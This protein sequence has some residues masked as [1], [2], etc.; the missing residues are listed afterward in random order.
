MKS[1]PVKLYYTI[2]LALPLS[3]LPGRA[4]AQIIPDRTLPNNSIVVPNSNSLTINGGTSAGSNLFHS[5]SE[6][7]LPTG[8]EAIFNNASN[9]QNI[10]SR[11]TGGK[12]S[13]IDGLIRANGTANLFF[14]N[15]SGII[16][17]Q[18]ARLNIGG[19]FIGSTGNS[20]QFSD[21][22]SFSATNPQAPPLLTVNV[23]VG[24]QV[25]ANPGAIRVEGVGHRF[26]VQ[27]IRNSLIDRSQQTDRGLQVK[28]RNT[29]AL[30]GGDVNLSGG[31]L[32]VTE[33]QIA[34]GSISSGV[35]SLTPTDVGWKLG[36][37][38]VQSF[39][40]INLSGQ[41]A[42]DVSGL[43]RGSIQ[44][45]GREVRLRD[46]SIGLIQNQ[47]SEPP[48]DISINATELLQVTGTNSQAT[49]PSVLV[50]ETLKDGSG[51]KIAIATRT[52]L[53]SDG[54]GIASRTFGTAPSGDVSVNA[55]EVVNVSSFSNRNPN[56]F[57]F[58]AAIS[59][60]AGNAGN[61]AILAQQITLLDGGIIAATTFN[62]GKGG[63]ITINASESVTV[64]GI[65]PIF[66]QPTAV[67]SAAISEGNAG[68]VTI[69][70]SRLIVTNGGSISTSTLAKGSGETL[71]INA[72][73]SIQVSGK[74]E[75]G[76]LPSRI[77][78]SALI[79]PE[80]LRR[81]LGLPDRPSGNSG[82]VIINTPRLTIFDGATVSVANQGT[83]LAG[84]LNINARE[85]LLN[86][87]G[88][89]SASTASG[90]GGNIELQVSGDSILRNGSQIA[91]EAAG[92][93]NGGNLTANT[94]TLTI[95]EG[96]KVT[97][98]A[99]Q[100]NGGNIRIVTQ[101]LFT[102]PNSR[103]T[104]SSSFG[105]SGTISINN[106]NLDPSSGLVQ[107]PEN[108][109]DPSTQIAQGCA[110]DE[111]NTFTIAGRGGLPEEPT[112]TLRG[113]TVWQDLQNYA[114]ESPQSHNE[115]SKTPPVTTIPETPS[116]VEAVGWQTNAQG[117]VELVANLP[118]S[119]EF[120][121]SDRASNKNCPRQK[122]E[123]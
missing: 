77:G 10:F 111:G 87:Q 14:I 83:G 90:I 100:G 36:Y 123:R 31:V 72:S 30:V 112:A 35:V 84:N 114:V 121:G 62:T 65:I 29:L 28:S 52:L 27:N 67:T 92:I 60:G 81:T 9:I 25:G 80:A 115:P 21:G 105:V 51:G 53:A 93:G 15:P 70:T 107:L 16:F 58:L 76:G 48:G 95:L 101:G 47:G 117:E 106:P 38:G 20:I 102:S 118:D 41:A 43:G 99:F 23:P 69:N 3:L 109:V 79:V 34:L 61:L 103:I 6:F 13:N 7:S 104:A 22:N 2:L 85:I 55:S 78:S 8:S 110:A 50:N 116:L 11:V 59:L 64:S 71:I 89:I 73:D 24:L 5:F 18:N 46:G 12:I 44:M 98:N 94:N 1:F 40:D 74:G 120:S 4:T 68:K 33:G 39:R 122:V 66:L 88:S 45:V 42:I 57:S 96:S 75:G 56:L 32:R 91:A 63:N 82:N 26:T 54:G 86:N 113:Q 17:G 119:A 19:S 37:Q 108:V 49:F 97:A